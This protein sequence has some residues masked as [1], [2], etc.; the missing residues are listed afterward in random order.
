MQTSPRAVK[1]CS[2]SRTCQLVLFTP[3]YQRLTIGIESQSDFRFS[4]T[5]PPPTHRV[6]TYTRIRRRPIAY[7]SRAAVQFSGLWLSVYLR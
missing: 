7:M 1:P 2:S 5:R 6:F 4:F 3:V